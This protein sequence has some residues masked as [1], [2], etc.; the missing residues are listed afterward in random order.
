MRAAQHRPVRTYAAV[1]AATVLLPLAVAASAGASQGPPTWTAVTVFTARPVS[2]NHDNPAPGADHTW[3]NASFTR[4]AS[5]SFYGQ[6]ARSYCPG[7]Y[8]G[9]CYYWIGESLDT[10]GTFTTNPTL[11]GGAH[12]PGNGTDGTGAAGPFTIGAAAR[13]VMSG[14]YHYGFYAS[15]DT[16]S[17]STV[18]AAENDHGTVPLSKATSTCTGGSS[19]GVTDCKW[20]EQFF[21]RGTQFWDLNGNR[22][23]SCLGLYGSWF[24][25]MPPGA[26]KY[27]SLV[28]SKWATASWN[29]WGAD[30]VDGNI[31]A[32]DAA[33]C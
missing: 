23:P 9:E 11:V 32:P 18:P 14:R 12:A 10:K 8:S 1:A 3:A 22:N 4:S 21:P 26:D 16:A 7:A 20:I 33:D 31:F 24:Y 15:V 29:N 19:C 6:V 30:P 28:M 2:G 13:G 5:V 17:G 27:C 25:Y